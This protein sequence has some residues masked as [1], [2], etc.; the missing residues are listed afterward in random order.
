MASLGIFRHRLRIPFHASPHTLELRSLRAQ[1]RHRSKNQEPFYFLRLKPRLRFRVKP[2]IRPE[3]IQEPPTHTKSLAGP[4]PPVGQ[5]PKTGGQGPTDFRS[6]SHRTQVSTLKAYSQSREWSH[7]VD[8]A[9]ARSLSGVPF[10]ACASHS[11]P[12]GIIRLNTYA[13]ISIGGVKYTTL[14]PFML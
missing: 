11:T 4:P 2:P 12:K 10:L 7:S 1:S 6:S 8:S 9:L 3:Q 13:N 5:N 14:I